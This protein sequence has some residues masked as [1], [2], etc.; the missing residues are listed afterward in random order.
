VLD[1]DYI[2]RWVDPAPDEPHYSFWI[3]PATLVFEDVF[4]LSVDLGQPWG[5]TILDITRTPVHVRRRRLSRP[6]AADFRSVA[7][8]NELAMPTEA[9]RLV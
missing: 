2:V 8:A 5:A 7:A 1:I 4:G 9:R 3:V 6:S